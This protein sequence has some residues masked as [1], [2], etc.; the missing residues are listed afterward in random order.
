M[1]DNAPDKLSVKRHSGTTLPRVS[2]VTNLSGFDWTKY[3]RKDISGDNISDLITRNND[4]MR[5]AEELEHNLESEKRKQVKLK[6]AV[7]GC[8]IVQAQIR[9]EMLKPIRNVMGET[10]I[11]EK[12]DLWVA[13]KETLDLADKVG[14]K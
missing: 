13:I 7:E 3:I 4:L 14:G 5:I 10:P 8:E 12:E 2:I 1:S 11:A 9:E 6:Q